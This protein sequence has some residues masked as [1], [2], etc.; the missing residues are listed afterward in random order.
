MD[1]AANTAIHPFKLRKRDNS[2]KKHKATNPSAICTP[3]N[4]IAAI[5]I[6][7]NGARFKNKLLIIVYPKV[8]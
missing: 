4:E 8:I 7:K 3:A 6:N 2:R 5:G 1:I